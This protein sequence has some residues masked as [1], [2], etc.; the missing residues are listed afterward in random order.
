MY[1][2]KRTGSKLT[3]IILLAAMLLGLCGCGT[4]SD[5]GGKVN[6]VFACN[7]S[8]SYED[9][10]LFETRINEL[11][12]DEGVSV[13]VEWL[14]FDPEFDS[15]EYSK[16]TLNLAL[17]SYQVYIMS[18]QEQYIA[19]GL[20]TGLSSTFCEN[21]WFGELAQYG[22]EQDSEYAGRAS[23]A[24]SSLMTELGFDE[25]DFYVSIA[26]YDYEQAVLDN[27]VALVKKL[28]E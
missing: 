23:L 3:A 10:E 25:I 5:S 14:L 27:S 18:D 17:D 22:I 12:A 15:Q 8:I 28:L 2:F 20:F 6:L 21:E 24:E 11:M 9:K 1:C 26:D 16:L 7:A 19:D 13:N 4:D